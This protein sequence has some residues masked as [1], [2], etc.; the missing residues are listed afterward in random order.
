MGCHSLRLHSYSSRCLFSTWLLSV[1]GTHQVLPHY[2]NNISR[3]REQRRAMRSQAIYWP[4]CD[5][6]LRNII[7]KHPTKEQVPVLIWFIYM[8]CHAPSSHIHKPTSHHPMS[9]TSTYPE[10]EGLYFSI[11][12]LC[13]LASLPTY[14]HLSITF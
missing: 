2:S 12:F 9:L 13:P 8:V 10:R 6:S 11:L 7:S 4:I 3:E 14:S 5:A 1:D